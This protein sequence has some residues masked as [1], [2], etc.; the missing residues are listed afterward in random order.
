MVDGATK[1]MGDESG[2][3]EPGAL[4][5]CIYCYAVNQYVA[6]EGK[7]LQ[8][9][10]FDTSTLPLEERKEIQKLRLFLANQPSP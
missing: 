10:A 9:Q 2:G 3:P 5:I 1:A 7:E 6:G 4:S 8:L